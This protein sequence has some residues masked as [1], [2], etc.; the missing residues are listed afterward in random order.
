MLREHSIFIKIQGKFNSLLMK[1]SCV[2]G[3]LF[4][5]SIIPIENDTGF[6]DFKKEIS[7][8]QSP[9]HNKL[10]VNIDHSFYEYLNYF[11]VNTKIIERMQKLSNIYS[12]IDEMKFIKNFREFLEESSNA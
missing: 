4:F 10:D 8:Y 9:Y 2:E 1:C 7:K 12:R 11:K 5:E 6:A 3:D